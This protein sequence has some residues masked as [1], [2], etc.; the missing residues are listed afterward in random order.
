MPTKD[1]R[2]DVP[3]KATKCLKKHPGQKF[4]SQE[5]AQWI[6]DNYPEE[7]EK[8]MNRTKADTPEKVLKQIQAEINI[9][10]IQKQEPK[11]KI[12]KGPKLKYYY[13]KLTDIEE[14]DKA[15]STSEQGSSNLKESDL[16][17][18]LADFLWAEFN[19]RSKRIDEKT[20]S[21]DRGRGGNKWLY[22]DLVG[23]QDISYDWKE[24]VR[25]CVAQYYDKKTTLWSFEV[26]FLINRSNLRESF[27]QTVSNSSWANYS[28]LVAGELNRNILNDLRILAA[29]HNIGF[30]LL[31]KDNPSE[32]SQV[33]IP[34]E[35][36]HEIDWEA[37]NRI[38]VQSSDFRKYIK[39]ITAAQNNDPDSLKLKGWYDIPD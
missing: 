4:L 3:E 9:P 38:S 35:Y 36:K 29:A 18:M 34:A 26:K 12:L 19:V 25:Q 14:V 15:E 28:Y 1:K 11:I 33:I 32:D 31:D 27:F 23:M 6:V 24:E 5:I 16:Y 13:S 39:Q 7:V 10:E 30:I 22:P 17:P 8:K 21:N 37:V 20:G 2:L